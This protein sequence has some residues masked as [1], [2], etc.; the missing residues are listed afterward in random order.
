[1]YIGNAKLTN[2]EETPVSSF[3]FLFSFHSARISLLSSVFGSQEAPRLL[4]EGGILQRLSL[5]EPDEALEK[6]A[7]LS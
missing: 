2:R 1:M 7:L 3:L 5:L 4:R 6:F